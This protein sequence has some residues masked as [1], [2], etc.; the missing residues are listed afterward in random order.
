MTQKAEQKKRSYAA[1]VESA[2]RLVR[3]RGIV[4][5]RVADV[6]GGAGLTVG[7]FYAHFPSKEAL[8]DEALRTAAAAMR[9][10]LFSGTGGTGSAGVARVLRR[11]LSPRHRDEADR[12]C[13]LPSVVGEVG[14]RAPEHAPVVAEQVDAMAGELGELLQGERGA[15]RTLALGLVALMYGGLAL[16]RATRGTPLSDEVL[17]ACRVTAAHALGGTTLDPEKT[18]ESS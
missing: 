16:S 11:Y 1:I 8:V 6:M 18:G 15:G 10:G 7:G 14:S 5:T 4:G 17:R 9:A 13:A 12:G 3:E 2:C